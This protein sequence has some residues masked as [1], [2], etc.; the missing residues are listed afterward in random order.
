MT[1][2][3]ISVSDFTKGTVSSPV[4]WSELTDTVTVLT[5]LTIWS[6]GFCVLWFFPDY[7]RTA[8]TWTMTPL[9]VS[10]LSCGDRNSHNHGRSKGSAGGVGLLAGA[11]PGRGGTTI[12]FPI[13]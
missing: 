8:M 3:A 2:M 10:Q 11:C 9:G 7:R 4:S 5:G 12:C 6:S 1:V 13:Q